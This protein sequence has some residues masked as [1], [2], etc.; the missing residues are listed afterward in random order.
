MSSSYGYLKFHLILGWGVSRLWLH[1]SVIFLFLSHACI[2]SWSFGSHIHTIKSMSIKTRSQ[3]LTLRTNLLSL[4]HLIHHLVI[5]HIINKG[6]NKVNKDQSQSKVNIIVTWVKRQMLIPFMYSH[7]F[8]MHHV[9]CIIYHS[10][11]TFVQ[12]SV[13]F[14]TPCFTLY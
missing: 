8:F 7:S 12:W 6:L 14:N 5:H 11:Y 1:L 4:F 13:Y 2:I 3:Q 10:A 9:C